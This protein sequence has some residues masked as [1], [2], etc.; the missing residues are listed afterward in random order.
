MRRN[1]LLALALALAAFVGKASAETCVGAPDAGECPQTA[2]DVAD[3]TA[4]TTWCD[5]TNTG[6]IILN[7]PVFVRNGATLT[8]NAPCVI[9]GQPR[10]AAVQAGQTAGTPGTLIIT[11]SGKINAVGTA[12][13]PI[14]FTTAAVDA[15]SDGV[16]DNADA[17]PSFLDP[18]PGGAATN[19]EGAPS[20]ALDD[21]PLS[22]PVSPLNPNG[23]QN[24]SLWGGVV[25]LGNAPTNLSNFSGVGHG[26]GL[27]EGLTVPGF[28]SANA[29]F[30][31]V[32]PHDNS[33]RLQYA[34]IR[35]AGDEIGNS[36][37]LN[38]LTL[39][40]VGDA[41]EISYVDCYANYDDGVEIFGG[42]V[43]T[44][45]M[46]VSYVGDDMFDLD[47][48]H[49]GTH[50]FWFGVQGNFNQDSGSSYGSASG[51]KGCECDGDDY[52]FNPSTAALH[53]LSTRFQVNSTPGPAA[54]IENTPWP[55][56][57][58]AIYNM[59]IIGPAGDGEA[60]PAVSPLSAGALSGKR[61]IDLRNGF[62]GRIFN[63][64]VVNYGTG[65]GID[66][67]NGDGGA[68]GFEA[69]TNNVNVNSGAA[70]LTA[71]GG[72]LIAVVTSTFDDVAAVGASETTALGNGDAIRASLGAP[73][74]AASLNCVNNAIF[75]GLA[76]EVQLIDPT[77]STDGAAGKF[78]PG[79]LPLGP[80][81]PDP[82]FGACGANGVRPVGDLPDGGA[83]YRGAFQAGEDNW[84]TGWTV[85]N[86]GG[87]LAD[88]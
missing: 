79:D 3:I 87:I 38:C 70:A 34:S 32:N 60:N 18:Y 30:G 24:V 39:A 72:P 47:Q 20:T 82:T 7:E 84:T 36:N 64:M 9:M 80:I 35:H 62:A 67:R 25:I 68:P 76:Q 45:H 42:T 54:A 81:D 73:N 27:V 10:Q 19:A 48:G 56:S 77:G 74:S 58:P 14:I 75:A 37:E 85:L 12:D 61:G 16:A 46:V 50:Q 59:T 63:T 65:Q 53:N 2:G 23:V 52:V 11:Q 49:T 21:S 31:G 43:D 8:I 28:P 57:N 51:D 55:L 1:S 88:N 83:T 41:T 22:A 5:A 17:K 44:H 29:K 69:D 86:L 4:N 40:G 6:P 13:A 15:N 78:E 33:G 26:Q 71:A 66:V